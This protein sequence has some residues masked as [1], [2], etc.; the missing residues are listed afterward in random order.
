[1]WVENDAARIIRRGD[2]MIP[3]RLVLAQLMRYFLVIVR[4]GGLYIP[5][6]FASVSAMLPSSGSYTYA[7]RNRHR[8]CMEQCINGLA[9]V[10]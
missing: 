2:A 1:M 8:V 7:Y 3:D 4:G 9:L 10:R 6:P 5:F